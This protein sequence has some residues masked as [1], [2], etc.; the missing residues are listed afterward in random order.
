[1]S[2]VVLPCRRL[3]LRVTLVLR[4]V[5]C[6]SVED[7]KKR[8]RAELPA[9][10]G[11]FCMLHMDKQDDEG[12]CLPLCNDHLRADVELRLML[13]QRGTVRKFGIKSNCIWRVPTACAYSV[14]MACAYSVCLWH[15]NGPKGC[16]VAECFLGVLIS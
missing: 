15:L 11:A 2:V 1:M 8:V 7:V 13:E 3:G 12:N 16:H 6:S 5:P 10:A 14:C 4:D 9:A